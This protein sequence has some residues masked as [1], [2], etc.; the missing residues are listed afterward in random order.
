MMRYAFIGLG[1]MASAILRGMHASPVYAHAELFGYDRHPEKAESLPVQYCPS[2]EQLCAHADV[3][4]LCV[5]PYSLD[6][7][8]V[9]LRPLLNCNCIIA[10]VAAGKPISWYE[11]RL[12]DLPFVRAMPNVNAGVNAGVTAICGGSHA[13]ADH[14]ALIQGIFDAVGKTYVLE[15]KHFSTFSAIAGAAPAYTYLYMDALA[16]AGVKAGLPKQVALSIAADMV[17]GSAVLLQKSGEH[18]AVLVDKV[19][20][21]GGTTIEGLHRLR[22][23]GFEHSVYEAIAAV[24]AKDRSLGS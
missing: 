23:L 10:S 15:E 16:S 19:C 20:S 8:L 9:K 3:L 4:M 24:I 6:D 7:L 2:L 21:P 18:P 14:V 1:N 5:K 13:T 12:P 17:L 22:E 11:E